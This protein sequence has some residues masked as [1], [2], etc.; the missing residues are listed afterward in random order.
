[1]PKLY[2]YFGLTVLFYANEHEPLHVHGKSQG[3]ES[4]AEIIVLNGTVVEVRYSAVAGRP[5]LDRQEMRYFEELVSAHA[6]DIV[7]KWIDF[8]VLHKP[9]VPER[10]TRRIK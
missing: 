7:A 5:P 10:I 6:S 9:I 2:E 1:M 8:F 3:R 4:R